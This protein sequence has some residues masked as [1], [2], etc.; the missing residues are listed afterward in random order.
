MTAR[1]DIRPF[2]R[3][4]PAKLIKTIASTGKTSGSQFEVIHLERG[5]SLIQDWSLQGSR[6][7]SLLKLGLRQQAE[8][9]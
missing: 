3:R 8:R 7:P 6:S 1:A 4:Y 5:S 2:P 9:A